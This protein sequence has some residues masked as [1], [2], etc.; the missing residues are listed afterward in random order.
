[1]LRRLIDPL[2]ARQ[3]W[4]DEVGDVLT[5]FFR[6]ILRPVPPLKSFLHGTWLGHPLH[7]LVTDVPVGALTIGLAL[8][9]IGSFDG[10]RWAT[11]LGFLGMIGAAVTG[12]AD[13]ADTEG[14]TRRYA[15]LHSLLM[16]LSGAFYL[17]SV[18]VRF[19][20]TPG[21][22]DHATLTAAIGYV[23]LVLGAYIGGDLVFAL[24][25]MVDRHAFRSAS[26][27]WIALDVGEVAEGAPTKARAG[28]QALL[29]VR[30]GDTIHAL[31]D[32][33]AHA[34]CSLSE[35]RIVGEEI[36]CA[37]HGSRFRMRDGA[38]VRGPAVYDQPSF[39]V[40]TSEGRLEVRR[41]GGR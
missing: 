11:L 5:G 41:R 2:L 29:L 7:P 37:C 36:E 16:F 39:E 31:H 28:A 13:Y 25:N 19:G 12:I 8:D 30:R 18:L 14:K 38:V 20:V 3:T 35:G 40:R 27:R 21:T 17:F 1:M 9:L 22:S 6:A 4:A 34:G 10:A 23:F 33:C 32:V 26:D 24:G 15:T